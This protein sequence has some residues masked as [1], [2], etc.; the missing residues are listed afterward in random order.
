MKSII[1]LL[2]VAAGIVLGLY[3]GVWLMFIGGIVQIIQAVKAPEIVAMTVAIGVAKIV[4]AGISGGLSAIVLIL[5]GY[6][7]LKG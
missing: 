6:S 2:L 1:G 5:P 3:V 7:M 4:F